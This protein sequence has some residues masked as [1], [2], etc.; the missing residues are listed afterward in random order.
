MQS[1]KM[2]LTGFWPKFEKWATWRQRNIFDGMQ[3][4]FC[5]FFFFFGKGKVTLGQLAHTGFCSMK[6]TR[7]IATTP[8]WDHASPSQV[9]PQHFVAGTHLYSWV[10]RGTES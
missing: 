7:S 5:F 8:G 6:P 2:L 3:I 4:L 1:C 9:T 10:K